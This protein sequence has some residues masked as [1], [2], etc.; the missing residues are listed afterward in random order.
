MRIK[1][2]GLPEVGAGTAGAGGA[3]GTGGAIR[4]VLPLAAQNFLYSIFATAPSTSAINP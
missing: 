1:I 2:R 3:G 4:V